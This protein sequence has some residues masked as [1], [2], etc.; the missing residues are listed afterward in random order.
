[1]RDL[2]FALN[3][4]G[5]CDAHARSQGGF[6]RA[7]H[8]RGLGCVVF[9]QS[10]VRAHTLVLGCVPYFGDASLS[11]S[12]NMIPPS[13]FLL[14]CIAVCQVLL[15]HPDGCDQVW[16][17]VP[18]GVGTGH[19]GCPGPARPALA[20]PVQATGPRGFWWVLHHSLKPSVPCYPFLQ[21]LRCMVHEQRGLR[22][23]HELCTHESKATLA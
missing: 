19:G 20:V 21:R 7:W 14:V 15:V 23:H 18:G 12:V 13:F 9:Q 11:S 6:V 16:H 8:V 1:V 17:G 5:S 22:L 10:P 4:P 3:L 2:V